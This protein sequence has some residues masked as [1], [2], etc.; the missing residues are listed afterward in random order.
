LS[1]VD[2]PSGRVLSETAV[3]DRLADVAVL[4]DRRHVLTVDEQR[5]ELVILY[6][7]G[8]R[9]VV[10][11]R[12][13]VSPYPVSVVVS[14]D[15]TRAAVASLWS[16]R[17]Q[18]I[19]ITSEAV[20]ARPEPRPPEG[21]GTGPLVRPVHNIHLPFAPRRMLWLPGSDDVVVADAF[22]GQLAVVN[23][24]SGEVVSHPEID[25]HNVQGLALSADG[26]RLLITHQRLKETAP[27]TQDSIHWGETMANLMCEI[28]LTDLRNPRLDLRPFSQLTF[29]GTREAGG[30]DPAG[31][32][33]LP[34][35]DRIAVALSGLNQLAVV[36][37][38]GMMAKRI[39]V[40]RRPLVVIPVGPASSP[41][42]S[43][44]TIIHQESASKPRPGATGSLLPVRGPQGIARAD[45]PSVP[46]ESVSKTVQ[47]VIT[48]N[49]L[50]DSLSVVDLRAG[51]ILREISLGPQPEPTAADRGER[52]FFDARMSHD[53]WMSCHSCHV[54]GHTH[55]LRADTLGDNSYGAPKR[56]PTLLGT[57][58]ADKWGWNGSFQYLHEQIQKS[59]TTTLRSDA[60]SP[61]N[62]LDLSAYLHTLSSPPPLEPATAAEADLAQIA[63]GRKVFTDHGCA[64]CH[65]PPLTYT[66]HDTHDVGLTDERG[67]T[68]FNAPSLRGVSQGR[69]FFH[70]NRARSLD[71]V[72]LEFNHPRGTVLSDDDLADLLRFLRSL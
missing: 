32:V 53:G 39:A 6:H 14:S 10:K 20:S 56:T 57:A 47:Q 40:G 48:L 58:I 4:P 41:D 63:R 9:L 3:G 64:R 71:D 19:D 42:T 51:R 13:P 65:V 2:V 66:S 30:G 62:A 22:A 52:L 1:L 69:R 72:F 25:G 54:N 26:R 7:D 34:A 36:E 11:S 59:L 70:D 18:T 21:I 17:L 37:R 50:D 60:V 5:H 44:G 49:S 16:R 29:L 28:P 31:L 45:K 24:K 38:G 46:P 33:V 43:I 27:I 23:T 8:G 35:T 68:K 12:H 61:Q 55:G 67:Q 15:G